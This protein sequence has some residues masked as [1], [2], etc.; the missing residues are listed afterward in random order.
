MQAM[1]SSS[2]LSSLSHSTSFYS[3]PEGNSTLTTASSPLHPHPCPYRDA[4]Q[5]PRELKQ[6]CQI[7]L[8]EQLCTSTSASVGSARAIYVLKC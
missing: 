3:L 5:L 7:F 6:H 1:A 4:R 2:P 8:E